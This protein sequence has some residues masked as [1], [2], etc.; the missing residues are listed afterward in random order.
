MTLRRRTFLKTAISGVAVTA[1]SGSLTSCFSND[2]QSKG[3]LNNFGIQLYSLKDIMP[4]DPKEVLK[5]LA[6]MGYTQIESFE[7]DKGM[8]WGMTNTEFKKY[9]DGL[10]L[11]MISSHC[12]YKEDFEK[13]AAEAA[14]IGM[15]YLIVPSVG[16]QKKIDDFKKIAEE[17]NQAGDICKKAGLRFA[18]H[19]HDYSFQPVEGQLPQDVMMQNTNPDTVDFEMDIYWV[20]TAGANPIEWFE[21]YPNRFRLCHIKD[22]QKGAPLDGENYSC[23]VGTGEIDFPK[24]LKVAKDKGLEYY[25]IEQEKF[26]NITTI[27]AAAQ[28]AAYMKKLVI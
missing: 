11:N 25:I 14:E 20:D 3:N 4:E 15:K 23:I 12:D 27:E 9:I 17:F 21:K 18:Y 16:P 13:K 7:G 19:N 2:T 22:R 1:I 26:D 10:G 28:N 6:G 5:K 8:F 24:V